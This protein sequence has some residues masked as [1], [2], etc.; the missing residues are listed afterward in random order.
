[1]SWYIHDSIVQYE[2]AWSAL[3]GQREKAADSAE[4]SECPDHLGASGDPDCVALRPVRPEASVRSAHSQRWPV[5]LCLR[6]SRVSRQLRLRRPKCCE[7]TSVSRNYA[8]AEVD[9]VDADRNAVGFASSY[10]ER[11]LWSAG[12]PT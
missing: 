9:S 4:E 3:D 2:T 1:M 8:G 12:S 10:S 5:Q 6:S 7:V 11:V